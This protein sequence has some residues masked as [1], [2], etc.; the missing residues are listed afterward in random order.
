MVVD[1]SFCLEVSLIFLLMMHPDYMHPSLETFQSSLESRK[2]SLVARE[3]MK[4]SKSGHFGASLS[5][6]RQFLS[7]DHIINTIFVVKIVILPT[8]KKS[9]EN[10]KVISHPWCNTFFRY[11][12]ISNLRNTQIAPLLANNHSIQARNAGKTR[13]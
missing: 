11:G 12:A 6:D 2:F 4:G 10:L 1:Y 5:L 9:K 13:F 3:T 7:F 8:D